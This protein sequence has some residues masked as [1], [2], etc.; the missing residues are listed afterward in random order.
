ME[1]LWTP[2]PNEARGQ[3]DLE[4]T[5]KWIFLL[6]VLMLS[7]HP[8]AN[9]TKARDLKYF[10]QRHCDQHDLGNG[11]G[12]IVDYNAD[13]VAAQSVHQNEN[14]SQGSKDNAKICKALD[15]LAHMKCSEACKYLLSNGLVNHA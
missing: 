13:I 12:L 14:R 1:A 6:L 7:K 10:V 11:K 9:G 3:L 4:R 8:P 15:L 2:Y 5:L